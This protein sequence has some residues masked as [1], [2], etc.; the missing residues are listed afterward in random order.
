MSLPLRFA[1]SPL[2]RYLTSSLCRLP[3]SHPGLQNRFILLSSLPLMSQT[4]G[5]AVLGCRG[6]LLI[7]FISSN[8]CAIFG[9]V[10]SVVCIVPGFSLPGVLFLVPLA[11]G[12]P[13]FDSGEIALPSL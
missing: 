9:V 4:T 13:S 11:F 8:T 12:V 7:S 3:R 2:R 1:L 10:A 5:L 6:S